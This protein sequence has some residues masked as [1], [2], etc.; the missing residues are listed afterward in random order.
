MTLDSSVRDDNR[1]DEMPMRRQA[2]KPVEQPQLFEL[3]DQA[4]QWSAGVVREARGTSVPLRRRI[5]P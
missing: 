2:Q 5:R 4:G 3:R 1:L